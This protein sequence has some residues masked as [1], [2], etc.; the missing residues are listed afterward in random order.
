V[1]D[2]VY[3]GLKNRYDKKY[4]KVD[5]TFSH[6]RQFR[7]KRQIS[8]ED[9]RRT[10]M[11]LAKWADSEPQKILD[12]AE[13]SLRFIKELKSIARRWKKDRP[14][15]DEKNWIGLINT[16]REYAGRYWA[17]PIF[18]NYLFLGEEIIPARIRALEQQGHQRKE[19]MQLIVPEEK[20]E[21]SE[22]LDRI[23]KGED[24]NVLA[25]EYGHLG[26]YYFWGNSY[27]PDD[28]KKL[29]GKRIVHRKAKLPLSENDRIFFKAVRKFALVANQADEAANLMI[30][31]LQPMW[32]AIAARFGITYENVANMR[33]DEVIESIRKNRLIVPKKELDRRGISHLFWYK[34][35]DIILETQD[36]DRFEEKD[37]SVISEKIKGKNASVTRNFTGM[38]RI[39]NTPKDMKKFRKGEILVTPMTNPQFLPVMEKAKAIITDDGGMLCHAAIVAR[40]MKKPCIVGTLNAT[41]ALKDNDM[42]SV[43]AKTGVIKVI[44]R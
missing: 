2:I 24:L 42:I 1:I 9:H 34:Q 33:I 27:T 28:L 3:F 14:W 18:Y 19:L 4:Y 11:I 17:G 35:G 23:S 29:K 16:F 12:I 10:N 21:M 5:L 25:E 20:T 37:D 8:K 32:E 26:R 44:K 13:T 31:T 43:N 15:T 41:K 7:N 30:H 36:L 40:E 39:V 38:V 6:Y 22:L